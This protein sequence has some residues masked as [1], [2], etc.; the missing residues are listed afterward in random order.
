MG[1]KL[2]LRP[3]NLKLI[4]YLEQII[5]YLMMSFFRSLAF[6]P[7]FNDHFRPF[8]KFLCIIRH[9]GLEWAMNVKLAWI[10]SFDT[11]NFLC[12]F[13]RA[14]PLPWLVPRVQSFDDV[15]TCFF[16]NGGKTVKYVVRPVP[17][18]TPSELR[19]TTTLY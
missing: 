8:L 14:S 19:I 3:I 6:D 13:G 1:Q 5:T 10:L 4:G 17:T 2:E 9:L 7:T 12:E 11:M 15:T 16:Q 18:I